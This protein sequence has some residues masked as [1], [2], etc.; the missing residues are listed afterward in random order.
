M[1][2]T[3]KKIP[4]LFLDT[5]I[6]IDYLLF[7]GHEAAAI[8]HIFD[9]SLEG[10][11][12]LSIAAHSL[13]NIYYSLRKEYAHDERKQ[14]IL[15]LSALCNVIEITKN[16]IEAAIKESYSEDLEDSLQIKC[17]VEA[18]CDYFI[19]RDFD[20]FENCPVRTVL[21]HE[22]ITELAI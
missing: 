9:A 14:L 18:E 13:T 3:D 15:N 4:H 7:R 10:E 12:K 20:L 8:E 17:A 2:N 21:P 1:K 6:L 11:V 19:T 16:S 22:L 5:N